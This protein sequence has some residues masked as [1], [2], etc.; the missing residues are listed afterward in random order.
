MSETAQAYQWIYATATADTSLMAAATGGV[1][2]GNA[3]IGVTAPYVSYGQQAGTDVLTMQAVRLFTHLL[4][5]IKAIGPSS[6]YAALVTIANRI[7]ALFKD[8]RNVAL[9][10]GFM[11]SSY[12]EQTIAYED[13]QLINGAQWSH[14]GGLY[15]IDLQGS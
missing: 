12:R 6:N 10:T 2:Q 14:L 15:H 5:Q 8:V 9:A 1:W 11:L 7:D 13:P 4:V 3:D